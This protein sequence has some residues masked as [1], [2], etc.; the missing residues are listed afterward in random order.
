MKKFIFIILTFFLLIGITVGIGVIELYHSKELRAARS[1][2]QEYATQN[3]LTSR[4][5]CVRASRS[6]E[7]RGDYNLSSFLFLPKDKNASDLILVRYT[8]TC[9]SNAFEV[10]ILTNSIERYGKADMVISR[11]KFISL[12]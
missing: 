11:G 3:N 10:G 2:A 12:P 4:L 5:T 8:A 6:W 9:P 7:K 1:I